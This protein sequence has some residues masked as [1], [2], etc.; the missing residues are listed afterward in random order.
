MAKQPES[1]LVK[2]KYDVW[3]GID[4]NKAGTVMRLPYEQAVGLMGE[5]KVERA[6]PLPGAE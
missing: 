1:L 5:G 3:T 4:R 2:L 6:D